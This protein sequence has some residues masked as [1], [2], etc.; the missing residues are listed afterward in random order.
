MGD[1]ERRSGGAEAGR[2]SSAA[3][4]GSDSAQIAARLDELSL[5]EVERIIERAIEIQA[6]S[7]N[8]V[9]DLIDTEMLGRIADELDIDPA[10]LARAIREE[11][12]RVETE[13]PSFT[14]HILGPRTITSRVVVPG[15]VSAAQEALD[16]WMQQHEGMRK[17]SRGPVRTTW[18]KDAGL[19]A[20]ARM[21]LRMSQGSGK[22]RNTAG[23]A[24]DIRPID[25][26]QT[27]VSLEADTTNMRR[28]AVGLLAGAAAMGLATGGAAALLDAGSVES[29]A[30]GV[31]TTAVLGGGILLGLR[32]WA[33]T[34]RAALA[35]AADAVA[36]PELVAGGGGLLSDAMSRWLG[37]RKRRLDGRGT[38]GG[39]RR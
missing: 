20:S 12:V 14:D 1:G 22:L 37:G 21:G 24:T 30:T 15:D 2:R 7:D 6:S 4:A 23:I 13:N 16:L 5:G 8:P 29:V 9:R 18:E 25:E 26:T 28:I 10:H 33:D 11:M 32:M 3:D 27:L 39:R 34:V 36:N 38:S 19:M 35:R 31:A 17:R